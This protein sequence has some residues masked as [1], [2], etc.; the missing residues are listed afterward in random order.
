MGR[1][2]AQPVLRSLGAGPHQF[3]AF[4][5]ETRLGVVR[6]GRALG[7]GPPRALQRTCASIPGWLWLVENRTDARFKCAAVG[8]VPTWDQPSHRAIDSLAGQPAA[9]ADRLAVGGGKTA[10]ALGGG[11]AFSAQRSCDARR[12]P[13]SLRGRRFLGL[14]GA[15]GTV[16][17]RLG[18]PDRRSLADQRACGRD[19]HGRTMARAGVGHSTN[20]RLPLWPLP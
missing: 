20:P 16:S 13:C 2:E 19:F 9:V 3:T 14:V 8:M 12:D 10:L 18:K 6:P 7:P 1:G 4:G 5:S 11:A 15:A 17:H